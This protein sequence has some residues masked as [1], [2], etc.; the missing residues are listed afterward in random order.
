MLVWHINL[1]ANSCFQ[2]CKCTNSWATSKW[3]I[4]PKSGKLG[5]KSSL[6][7]VL[8]KQIFSSRHSTWES[9]TLWKKP[10]SGLRNTC[11]PYFHLL[12]LFLQEIIPFTN[13]ILKKPTTSF[14]IKDLG[15]KKSPKNK[16]ET[17]KTPQ[18]LSSPK[19]KCLEKLSMWAGS[20][21]KKR[22]KQDLS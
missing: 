16:N 4:W 18:P 2:I 7:K 13:Y 17:K 9:I 20:S 5:K 11:R 14:K 22:K 10:H 21:E 15:T 19:T 3:R 6:D 12:F 8:I 1:S